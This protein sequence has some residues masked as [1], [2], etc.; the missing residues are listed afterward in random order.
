MRR[1]D[2]ITMVKLLVKATVEGR[3]GFE[4][5]FGSVPYAKSTNLFWEIRQRLPE[6]D[7]PVFVTLRKEYSYIM[8]TALNTGKVKM[9]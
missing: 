9:H 8:V 4:R 6:W 2:V 3:R 1:S 7:L 5:G